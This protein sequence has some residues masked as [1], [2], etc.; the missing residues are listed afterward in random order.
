M[1]LQYCP[2]I[3]KQEPYC[4][5]IGFADVEILIMGVVLL[6]LEMLHIEPEGFPFKK[7]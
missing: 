2:D 1:I 3:R 4:G 7:D 6:K 5:A